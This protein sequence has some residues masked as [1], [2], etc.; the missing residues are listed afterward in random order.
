MISIRVPLKGCL[1]PSLQHP[2]CWIS[3]NFGRLFRSRAAKVHTELFETVRWKLSSI[4]ATSKGP[5]WR[6]PLKRLSKSAKWLE[7]HR[8]SMKNMKKGWENIET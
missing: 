6:T 7:K 8:K 3:P 2:S 5:A 4:C 1:G